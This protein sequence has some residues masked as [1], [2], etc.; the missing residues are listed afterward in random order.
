RPHAFKEVRIDR[1]DEFGRVMTPK[2]AFRKL[3]HAFHGKGPGKMKQ[4]KRMRAYE[5]DLKRKGMAAGDTPMHSV[6]R[7]REVQAQTQ[8]PYVVI[9]GH[10]KPGQISD[11]ANSFATMERE[12]EVVGSLTPMLGD[13][14][15]HAPLITAVGGGP[16]A[17]GASD[18]PTHLVEGGAVSG[19]QQAPSA[20]HSRLVPH[21]HGPSTRQATPP[22]MPL[23]P[24]VPLM[25]LMPIVPLMP[26]MPIVPLMPL[27]PIVPL[28]PLMPIVP[29]M[30]LM[31]IVPLMPLMPIVPL[32]PLMP[33]VPLMPLMPIVPVLFCHPCALCVLLD[34]N[35]AV[36]AEAQR[37][38]EIALVDACVHAP[39]H[40]HHLLHAH[41]Y[42]QHALPAHLPFHPSIASAFPSPIAS[43]FPSPIAPA[44]P[45]PIAP[46]F[47][48]P[49]APAFPSPIAPAFPSPMAPAFPSPIPPAFPSPIAPAFPSPIAP[50]FPSPMAP[51][52]PSPIA[53]AFP[54]PIA[55][56][57]P[58]PL[59]LPFPPPLHLPFP[60]PS[61]LP[62]PPPTHLPS[63]LYR[64][65]PPPFYRT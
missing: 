47:P 50:A 46:A 62:S 27:M 17:R 23:M 61:H 9:T 33:I 36:R 55:P 18:L 21:A 57:F 5:E 12:R 53:P 45:S 49:I 20:L 4:E 7:L 11:P 51:A 48:S 1:I 38:G 42:W 6:E 3:S 2:E 60:P 64:P 35:E 58:P 14:K 31:P 22:L 40:V 19:H 56:A 65:S 15:L 13:A 43:A 34:E 63:P 52:F 8:S 24:I 26:L 54:S 59:H 29:L 44:F 39:P 37:A 16:R 30:P 41:Q 10:V 32:M 25:P 28:M